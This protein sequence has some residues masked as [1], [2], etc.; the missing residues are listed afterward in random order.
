M[1]IRILFDDRSM[2]LFRR[3]SPLGG[4][5]MDDFSEI[6]ENLPQKPARSRLERYG[7]LIDELLRMGWTYRAIARILADKCDVH[8][9][10][11]TI[12]HFVR[13]RRKMKRISAKGQQLAPSAQVAAGAEKKRISPTESKFMMDSAY[14]KIAALKQR[15]ASAPNASNPFQYDP[16]EPLQ[17][18]PRPEPPK[19]AP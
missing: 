19:T 15:P 2:L 5:A 6:L 17:L 8:V 12:H 18:I 7:A 4:N 13:L 10:I 14:Q 11:S 16:E 3:G 9:S 1:N